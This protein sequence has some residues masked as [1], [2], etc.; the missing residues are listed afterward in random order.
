MR[1]RRPVGRPSKGERASLLLRLD[2]AVLEAVRGLA[3]QDMRSVNAEVEFL[4]RDALRRRGV[5]LRPA[6]G[7][8]DRDG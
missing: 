6:G 8:E 4:L 3:E 7:Q 2:P 1:E 5:K